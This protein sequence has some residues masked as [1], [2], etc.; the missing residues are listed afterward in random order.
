MCRQ[1]FFWIKSLWRIEGNNNHQLSAP[2]SSLHIVFLRLL[3][4]QASQQ[5]PVESI[6]RSILTTNT[7]A[8]R[9]EERLRAFQERVE[10]A[11]SNGFNLSPEHSGVRS[12]YYRDYQFMLDTL[13]RL[14]TELKSYPGDSTTTILHH[15]INNQS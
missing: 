8:Q 7:Q 12:A 10:Y 6:F 14:G 11:T 13:A 1:L 2:Y 4:M 9:A 5:A 15:L 3:F